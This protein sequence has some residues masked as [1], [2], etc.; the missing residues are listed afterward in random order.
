MSDQLTG[1]A[2][3]QTCSGRQTPD[4]LAEFYLES[5]SDPFADFLAG[6]M[7]PADAALSGLSEALRAGGLV[8]AT[9]RVAIPRMPGSLEETGVSAGMVQQITLKSLYSRGE[10]TARALAAGL[11]LKFQLVRDRKSTRLNSSH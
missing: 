6:P 9:P 8:D 7:I 10:L 1:R 5:R 3:S 4:P 2:G 11:G